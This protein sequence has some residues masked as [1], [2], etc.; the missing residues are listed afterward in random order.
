MSGTGR[1]GTAATREAVGRAEAD[2]ARPGFHFR[3]PAG[4]M[5]DPN[6]TIRL[7]DHYH[8][9]YQHN[10]SGDRWGNIHWGHARS[11][12]LVHWEHLPLA[13]APEP[14]RGEGH[15]FT[16]SA[17]TRPD[18]TPMLFYSSFP[19]SGV[20]RPAEQ[21]AV[22]CDPEL[23]R[24]RRPTDDNPILSLA[25]HGGPAFGPD[26][27]DPFVFGAEGRAFLVLGAVLEDGGAPVLA[28]YEARD[29]GLLDWEYRGLLHRGDPD[30]TA[31]FECP[32]LVRAGGRD[33][34]I[35]S[36]HR[37]VE[38]LVGTFDPTAP[39]FTGGTRV[40]LDRSPHFYATGRMAHAPGDDPVL[41]GW[42]RGWS[43][44]RGWNGALGL[45]RRL[46]VGP[47]GRPRQRPVSAVERLRGA[48]TEI[49]DRTLDPDG[50]DGTG[51][52]AGSGRDG[53]AAA[54]EGPCLE[55][56]AT[57]RPTAGGAVGLRVVRAGGRPLATVRYRA[58][59]D[60]RGR[61]EVEGESWPLDL[62]PHAAPE[63]GRGE[64]RPET[65]TFPLAVGPD[66]PLELRLFWDRSLL[67]L[68]LQ[69]GREVCTRVI[70]GGGEPVS[71]EPFA[72]GAT[73]RVETLRVWVL[74]EVW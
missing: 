69:G 19:P 4:W 11:R 38:C 7:G 27:R 3:P 46:S 37:P 41:V 8:L 17:W 16:G 55:A 48:G 44:G 53:T 2:P 42:V 73:A 30:E 15:C 9:F 33:L 34:L 63:A 36:A 70:A 65:T 12:D 57:L 58:A 60:G 52:G 25:D 13:L 45:P 67:E 23:T 31:F 24:F 14:A 74:G 6:G 59:A 32:N 40:P 28:L 47:D 68:F 61:L 66:D 50:S 1:D 10:P 51:G 29:D 56:R 54:V 64:A 5:N 62:D 18:G 22:E 35:Y 71:V 39:A 72:E 49:R 20:D 43:P 21:W 26:W